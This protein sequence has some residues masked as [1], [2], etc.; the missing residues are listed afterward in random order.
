[1]TRLRML[2]LLILGLPKTI[3]FQLQVFSARRGH[4]G[5]RYWFPPRMADAIVRQ[6]QPVGLPHG[7]LRIGYGEIGISIKH[8]SRRSGRCRERFEFKGT[9][10]IGHGSKIAVTGTLAL[11]DGVTIAAETAIVAQNRI[12]IGDNALVSWDVLIIDTDG[13]RIYDAGGSQVNAATPIRIGN[14]VWI[15]CR[16]LVLKES[17]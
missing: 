16:R 13:H 6:R 12:D 7:S 3:I 2:C 9:A 1:M 5:C 17:G 4:Q 10:D 8:R 15:G 14:S 11:G